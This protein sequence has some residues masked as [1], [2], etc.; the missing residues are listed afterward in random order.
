VL[1]STWRVFVK[2]ADGI[3]EKA[4]KTED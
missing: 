2:H 3:A 4:E 1:T